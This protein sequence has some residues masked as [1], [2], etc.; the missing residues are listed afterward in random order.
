MGTTVRISKSAKKSVKKNPVKAKS[1][2]V[3]SKADRAAALARAAVAAE[4][5][6]KRQNEAFA[7]MTKPQ[8]RVAIAKD[9]IAQLKAKKYRA[10]AGTYLTNAK[11]D[12]VLKREDDSPD[13]QLQQVLFS[14]NA[15]TCDVCGIGALMV[16]GVRFADKLTVGDLGPQ[17]DWQWV[18]GYYLNT[19]FELSQIDLI[20]SAFETSTTV[21]RRVCI[22]ESFKCALNDAVAFGRR[23]QTDG[24]RMIAI[25][26]NIVRNRGEFVP[27]RAT[28]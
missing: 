4:K 17:P 7:K 23:Y 8:Q 24:T 26:R 18:I 12:S 10:R 13:K 19:W 11:L 16:S 21:G 25:M 14:K 9:V 20:E 3:V 1:A 6:I 28:K 15:G 5:A 27:P 22:D 2:T